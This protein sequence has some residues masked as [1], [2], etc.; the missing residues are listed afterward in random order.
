[1]NGA[2][3]IVEEAAV[4]LGKDIIFDAE[5]DPDPIGILHLQAPDFG[6]VI[7]S[8]LLGHAS[9]MLCQ[10][11][12]SGETDLRTSETDRLEDQFLGAVSSVAIGCMGMVIAG[13]HTI[14]S[15]FTLW[16][17]TWREASSRRISSGRIPSST[18][19]TIT[20]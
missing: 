5:A 15:C 8:A 14:F 12:M 13:H 17:I 11:R 19:I 16:S 1:M 9:V 3:G 10:M 2:D 4:H 6:A 7:Q 20:W 18:I